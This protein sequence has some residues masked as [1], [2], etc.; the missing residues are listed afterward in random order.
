MARSLADT[1]A[2]PSASPSE[3]PSVSAPSH[4][5]THSPHSSSPTRSPTAAPV[6]SAP[7]HA[8]HSSGPSKSPSRSPTAGPVSTAPSHSP[9]SSSPTHSPT[10]MPTGSPTWTP[11][12]QPSAMLITA[13]VLM[14]VGYVAF[15]GLVFLAPAKRKMASVGVFGLEL[16]AF[17]LMWGGAC[18]NGCNFSGTV[19]AQQ[20]SVAALAISTTGL[21]VSFLGVCWFYRTIGKTAQA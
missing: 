5:P 11:P 3:S 1:T 8:P 6:S 13:M 20:A 2:S 21:M 18:S 9:H 15:A 10:R 19:P 4:S 17:L 16:L 7:S 12:E 14:C